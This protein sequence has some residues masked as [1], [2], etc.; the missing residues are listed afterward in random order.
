MMSRVPVEMVSL[1][2]PTAREMLQE[3]VE[4]D[5]FGDETMDMLLSDIYDCSAQLWASLDADH[6][7]RAFIVTR[8]VSKPGGRS[9][10]IQYAGG[11]GPDSWLT[12][13]REVLLD[14]ARTTGCNMIELFGRPGWQRLLGVKPRAVACGMRLEH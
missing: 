10:Q 14:F 6:S 7:P 2:W 11:K 13:A 5:G 8:I 9:L 3:A 4:A 1:L 12:E